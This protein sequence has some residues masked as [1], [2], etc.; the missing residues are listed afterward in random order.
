MTKEI[1]AIPP[2]NVYLLDKNRHKIE[3]GDILK[4]YHF[5]SAIRR[6]KVYMYKQVVD[7]ERWP[8][9]DY[10]FRISHLSLKDP[11]GGYYERLNNDI[12]VGCE[13]V[14]GY[15]YV[16]PYGQISHYERPKINAE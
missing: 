12:Y 7:C 15:T 16:P 3:V 9:G 5:R 1:N 14:E 13:I 10:Y 11:K 6:R 2:D 4:L 8:S